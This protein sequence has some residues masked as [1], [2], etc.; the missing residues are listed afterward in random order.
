MLSTA[1]LRNKRVSAV[2][3]FAFVL[4][5]GGSSFRDFHSDIFSGVFNSSGKPMSPQST[6]SGRLCV[7]KLL[8]TRLPTHFPLCVWIRIHMK[9]QLR[10]APL[11]GAAILLARYSPTDH[12][13]TQ[14]ETMTQVPAASSPYTLMC[15]S[16][17]R[18]GLSWHPFI[19]RPRDPSSNPE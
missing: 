3:E 10:L 4:K 9:Q 2:G 14:L 18:S 1:T 11:E 17:R 7:H 16:R 5:F 6:L 15:E 8:E 19:F 13:F 12:A